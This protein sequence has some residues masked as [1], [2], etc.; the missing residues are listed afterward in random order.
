VNEIDAKDNNRK[1]VFKDVAKANTAKLCKCPGSQPGKI[2]AD[3]GAHLRGCRFRK[4]SSQ[5]ATKTSVIPSKII[6]GNSLAVAI[7]AEDF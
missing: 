7:G 4:R 1:R 5:Y 6:D 2:I 3:I